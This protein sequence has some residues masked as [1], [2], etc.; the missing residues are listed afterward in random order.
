[1][2]IRWLTVRVC[3]C[4]TKNACPTHMFLYAY[5]CVCVRLLYFYIFTIHIHV[6]CIFIY[7]TLAVARNKN[8]F[9]KF[10]PNDAE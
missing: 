7:G 8:I 4:L 1:M 10:F 3:L 9:H 2:Y 6:R 5:V